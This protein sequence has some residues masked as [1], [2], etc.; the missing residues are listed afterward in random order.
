MSIWE[1][2]ARAKS[3][4]M[5]WL[6]VALLAMLLC[7]VAM[8]TMAQAQDSAAL[9]PRSFDIP[10]QPLTEALIQFGRQAGLQA[11]TDPRLVLNL[12]SAPV[13]GV[14]TWQQALGTLLAG[15]GLTYRLNGSL[16]T[17]ERAVAE[18]ESGP[19][20]LGDITVT[21]RRTEELV[22]DVPGSV[23]VLPSQ[24]IEESNIEDLEDLALFTPNVNLGDAG[25]RRFI[26]ISIRGI[27]NLTGTQTSG[28]TVGVYLDEVLLNPTGS[29]IGVDPNL[30][31]L[32]R[33]EVLYGPQG[34]AFGRGT[35]GGAINYVTRKPTE[36]F[37][38]EIDGEV[39]SHPDGMVRGVI[40]GSLTGDR[41][42]MARLV[43]FGRY[44]DGFIDTPNIGGSSDEQDYGGRLSLRSQPMDRLTLDLSGSFDRTVYRVPNLATRDSIE[45]DGNLEFLVTR[46]GEHRI[47]RALVTFRG[48]YDFDAGTLISNTSYLD[49]DVKA[50]SDADLTEFDSGFSERP[51]TESA[52]GQEIRFE[53]E[54]FSV[55]LLG[56]TS[57]LLGANGA[58]ADETTRFKGF[59]PNGVLGFEIDTGREVFDIGSFG[60]VRFRPIEKLEVAV[61]GRFTYNEV[62]VSQAGFEDASQSFTNFS[63]KAS[64]LYDWTDDLSTYALVSTGF[65]S[66][67]F[68][69]LGTGALSGR[70]FD[71]ET[72][73]NY[74]AGVKSRW[75]DDR[76]FVNASAFA[77][78]YDNIQVPETIAVGLSNV[79]VLDNAASARS[80][81]GELGVAALPL[82]GLQLN[83]N[84][85]YADARFTDY[86][87]SPRGDLSDEPLPNAPRHTLSFIAD[88]SHP[89]FDDFADAFIRSEYS[90]TSSFKNVL[91]PTRPNFD[92]YD[93][94]NLRIGLRAD[95]FDIEAFVENVFD[96]IYV[97]GITGASGFTDALGVSEPL[98]VGT[99]RRFGIRARV[100]F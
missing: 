73:I 52:I 82:E 38:A 7:G 19:L 23:F 35:I 49:T 29:T 74:E 17:L 27:S 100:R 75:F 24:E 51:S 36:D 98:E 32:E 37:E 85:G 28:P 13:A 63:P 70:E 64:L 31:D 60:E 43:A 68:N 99:P 89:V 69:A 96:E 25:E 55:P 77:L 71:S 12:R 72:A 79:T 78:F 14:M 62:T 10:A 39:G 59:A 97:T 21:A 9:E 6:S 4:R 3:G 20:R 54:A 15:T 5:V 56:Q 92:A 53:S 61:G 67:G 47:D 66:G 44:D 87:D 58:W 34:T 90:F 46:D 81:G 84:Y 11:S 95:R 33:A 93:V 83:L 30:F 65:K 91:A 94:L 8:S 57:F 86:E 1:A 45:G 40:N 22:Q 26:D 2:L 76:L 18:P 50:D 42:L 41:N 48:A 16:V 80:L 88:Y